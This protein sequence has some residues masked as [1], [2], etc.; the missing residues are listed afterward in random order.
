MGI[1]YSFTKQKRTGIPVFLRAKASKGFQGS[2]AGFHSQVDVRVILG[3]LDEDTGMGDEDM[4]GLG[5]VSGSLTVRDVK[6]SASFGLQQLG[7]GARIVDYTP[8]RTRLIV[9]STGQVCVCATVLFINVACC[10]TEQRLMV[11]STDQISTTIPLMYVPL[12]RQ[13]LADEDVEVR[14]VAPSAPSL[15]LLLV[16]REM[17]A[18]IRAALASKDVTGPGLGPGSSSGSAAVPS[19]GPRTDNNINPDAFRVSSRVDDGFEVLSV[20][21]GEQWEGGEGAA[22]RFTNTSC[23]FEI[24]D[25]FNGT[26]WMSFSFVARGVYKATVTYNGVPLKGATFQVFF[27][28]PLNNSRR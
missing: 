27:G 6:A 2:D 9:A 18:S 17:E 24:I 10:R 12:Y 23:P 28:L 25:N 20:E 5:S 7:V 15:M 14:F 21:A 8:D 11:A 4:I 26:Y 3:G 22:V 13:V 16:P 1:P 19:S